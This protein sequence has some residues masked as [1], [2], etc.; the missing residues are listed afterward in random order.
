MWRRNKKVIVVAVLAAVVLA[1]AI[2]GAAAYAQ[3][4]NTTSGNNT[5]SA[6][7]ARILGI[8]QQKVEDAFAQA[9]SEAQAEALDNYLKNL[10]TQGKITQAQAD[11]YKDWVKSKPN[12][13]LPGLFGGRGFRGGMMRRF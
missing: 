6:R 2:G 3:T 9:R 4:S 11:Q 8:D 7:V 13:P 1:A 12:V 5:I 10:V